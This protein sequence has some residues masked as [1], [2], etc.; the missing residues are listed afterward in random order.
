MV[1]RKNRRLGR[2]LRFFSIGWLWLAFWLLNGLVLDVHSLPVAQANA[3][4]VTNTAATG[5]GSLKDAI[6]QANNNIGPDTITFNLPS[7]PATIAVHY[8]FQITDELIIYGPGA[9]QLTISGDNTHRLFTSGS[10]TFSLYN[11]TLTNGNAATEIDVKGGAIYQFGGT[12]NINNVVINNSSAVTQNPNDLG[13]G[14]AIYNGPYGT[15][16]VVNS[17]ISGNT[18]NGGGG[19]YNHNIMT[20][21]NS[22]ISGNSSIGGSVGGGG[23]FNEL[24]GRMTV[25]NSTLSNNITNGLGGGLHSYGLIQ[26]SNLTIYGNK[27]WRGGGFYSY[28]GGIPLKNTIVAGNTAT[29]AGPDIYGAITSQGYNLVQNRAASSGYLNTDLPNGTNPL[30]GPLQ[31][32]GGLTFTRNLAPNSPAINAAN[33][34]GCLDSNNNPIPTDQRGLSRPQGGRCDI[35][36]VEYGTVTQNFTTISLA[37]SASSITFGQTIQLTATVDAESGTP[38]GYV[39][40]KKDGSVLARVALVNGVAT[41][42]FQPPHAGNYSFTAQYE[43]D[44]NFYPSASQTINLTVN[45]APTTTTL[46]ITPNPAVAGQAVTLKVKVTSALGIVP[47]AVTFQDNNIGLAFT[48]LVNGEGSFTFTDLGVGTHNIQATSTQTDDFNAS[49]SS[50]VTLTINQASTSVTLDSLANAALVGQP[51][52]FT[53]VVRATPPGGGIA[54]GAVTFKEGATTLGTSTLD[55]VGVATFTTSALNLGNHAITAEYSGDASYLASASGAFNQQIVDL[56]SG[57]VVN[58]ASDDGT[59]SNCG[60]LSYAIMQAALKPAASPPFVIGFASSQITLTTPLGVIS[61]TNGVPIVLNGGCAIQ[62]GRGVPQVKLV[63]ANGAD[64][65]ALAL[66]SNVTVKGFAITGFSGNAV[67]I[68]GD[69]NTLACNWIGTANGTTAVANGG[70]VR[71]AGSNNNLGQ[72]DRPESGNLISGNSGAAIQFENNSKNNSAYY[73]RIGVQWDNPAPLKNGSGLKL[74]AGNQLKLGPGNVVRA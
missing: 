60:T 29:D 12:L 58:S 36:A 38:S 14:G 1:L 41:T 66:A 45:R 70:G 53:A 27:A 49:S 63:K 42:Q 34:A 39:T 8:G 19:L 17:T 30:L 10:P 46:T 6:D 23:L 68:Q 73:N 22:T 71:L 50:I 28:Q 9:S 7:Y 3:L 21:V 55:T 43:G 74:L 33:P 13:Q 69:N 59:G 52:T 57:Q 48:D 56:C 44:P 51:V 4:V 61:N 32:N 65:Q 40:F 2:A 31:N 72:V 24:E 47:G 64:P 26:L 11:L 20:I 62:N 35:G 67:E 5:P 37:S 18:A 25:V 15:V 54:T 16:N